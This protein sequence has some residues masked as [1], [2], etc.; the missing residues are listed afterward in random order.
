[1]YKLLLFICWTNAFSYHVGDTAEVA[2]RALCS[3]ELQNRGVQTESM[4]GFE[5]NQLE[6]EIFQVD[7]TLED[8]EMKV[9]V[10][11]WSVE[12][13]GLQDGEAVSIDSVSSAPLCFDEEVAVQKFCDHSQI[14]MV[15]LLCGVALLLSVCVVYLTWGR[16]NIFQNSS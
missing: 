3:N 15:I 7:R 1:M 11:R 12:A 8:M 14:F 5:Q 2:A 4:E 13:Q 10:L 9:N 6:Q 16:G